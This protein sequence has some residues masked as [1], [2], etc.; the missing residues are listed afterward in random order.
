MP[1]CNQYVFPYLNGL[2]YSKMK[3]ILADVF[4]NKTDNLFDISLIPHQLYSTA[5]DEAD[6]LPLADIQ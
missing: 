6:I 5:I 3:A 4:L 1:L 2:L